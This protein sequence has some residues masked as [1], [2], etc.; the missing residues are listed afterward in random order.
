VTCHVATD[1]GRHEEISFYIKGK[2]NVYQ[3]S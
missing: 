3:E 1:G 2:N